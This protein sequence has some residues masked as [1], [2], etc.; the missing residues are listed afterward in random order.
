MAF[1]RD[2]FTEGAKETRQAARDYWLNTAFLNGNQWIYWDYGTD[3]P[4]DV[5]GDDR[6]RMVMNRMATNHRTLIANLMQR[7]ITYEVLPN[8]ADDASQHAAR[9]AEELLRALHDDHN[10]ENLREKSMATVLKGGTCAIALDWDSD[11]DDTVETVLSV[12][13]FVVEPGSRDPEKARW[14]IKAQLLPPVEVQQT[15]GLKDVPKPDSAAG[16]NP[17]MSKLTAH[18]TNSSGETVDQTLVLTY[19]ERPNG[20]NKGGF[21]VE[22]GGEI[23]EEGP[24]N[25]P[26]RDRLNLVVGTETVQ[27]DKWY[28]ET[29]YNQA[30]SPQV[31]LN[32]AWSNLIE[33]LRDAS[34]ARLLVPNSAVRFLDQATDLPGEMLAYPDGIQPP[35]WLDPAQLPAWLRQIPDDLQRQLDDIMGVHDVSRGM[36]PANL[37]SGT[38]LSILAEKDSSPVGRLIKVTAGMWTR[39]GRMVLQLQEMMVKEQRFSVIDTDNGP[40]ALTWTGTDIA[41]Q[42][43]ARVPL[44]GIIPISRAAQEQLATKMLEMGIITSIP[45][46]T[47]VSQVPNSKDMI[48]RTHPAVAK[49]RRE[50]GRM[51]QG[52]VMIPATFDPHDVHILE[53]NNFRM[54]IAYEMMSAELQ[55]M[56]DDHVQA[57]ETIAAEAAAKM[58]QRAMAGPGLAGVPSANGDP[59]VEVPPLDPAVAEPMPTLPLSPEGLLEPIDPAM[60]EPTPDDLLA[61]L[62]AEL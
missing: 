22:V 32:S 44:E 21:K 41:G 4:R 48:K 55:E 62:E 37:E 11:L 45:E 46:W 49:A 8:G 6:V 57:H 61:Q 5:D 42:H 16:L 25:Y 14:W 58:E 24:W 27:E 54:S 38:A 28:G 2:K 19:Y 31:A 33:H 60:M 9:V 39:L 56:V 3:T 35:S 34:V 7:E 10:W 26:F 53:H 1:V 36:A 50:N 59:S 17:L 47:A 20:K 18:S 30:R 40:L 29:I 13:E 12:A 15:F 43:N 52:E 23:V 51:A